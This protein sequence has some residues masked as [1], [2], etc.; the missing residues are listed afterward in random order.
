MNI[1]I[2]G[3]LYDNLISAIQESKL[4]KKIYTATED[5]IDELPNVKYYSIE[6]L[7]QKARALQIDIAVNTD[8]S[9][10]EKDIVEIFKDNRINLISVNKKWLNLE[11]SRLASKKLMNYYSVNNPALIKAPSE[12]PVVLKTNSD[13]STELAYSM[14]ELVNKMQSLEGE[15]KYIEEFLE[16]ENF[17]LLCLWDKKNLLFFNTPNPTNEVKDD[18]LYLLKTKLSFMFSDEKADFCGFF[19]IRLIWVKND[20]YV[21][22][23]NMGFDENSVFNQTNKDFLYILNSAIYQKLNEV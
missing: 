16:G 1:L 14:E 6:N 2:I 18:R 22:D 4:P 23:F 10:I 13:K 8:K 19:T 9:L 17:D 20:W 7:V 21:K 3:K 11:T 5:P 12:F 15:K